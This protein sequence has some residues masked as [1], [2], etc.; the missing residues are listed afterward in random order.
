MIDKPPSSAAAN[1]PNS[2]IPELVMLAASA[3]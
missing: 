2:R 3:G 1:I